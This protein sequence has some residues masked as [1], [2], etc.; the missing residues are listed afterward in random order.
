MSGAALKALR[1]HLVAAKTALT[2]GDLSAARASCSEA[3]SVDGESYD[4]WTFDGKVAF[5]QGDVTGA[6][7][8]Y[9]RATDIRDDHPAAWQG[10]AEASEASGDHAL[11]STALKTLLK[12]PADDKAVT[13]DKRGEWR[14]RLPVALTQANA[15]ADASDA[16]TDLSESA[17]DDTAV[18][19][20][21]RKAAECALSALSLIHI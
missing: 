13:E 10:I 20:S 9:R 4:A 1:T 3:L 18:N 2:A 16:W 5:A 8:S 7:T 11:C 6:L 17:G 21:R 14:R 12:M 19:A 15:W